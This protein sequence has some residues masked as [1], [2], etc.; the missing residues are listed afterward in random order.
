M[1]GRI[2]DMILK[3]GF[4][5]DLFVIGCNCI[6]RSRSDSVG[7][8]ERSGAEKYSA[9]YLAKITNKPFIKRKVL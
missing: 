6:V 8:M 5:L 2:G 4:Y 7:S 9:L 3:S 1:I